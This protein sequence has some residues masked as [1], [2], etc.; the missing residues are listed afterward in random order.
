MR[1]CSHTSKATMADISTDCASP[2]VLEP[3]VAASRDISTASRHSDVWAA[4]ENQQGQLDGLLHRVAALLSGMH[5]EVLR[6]VRTAFSSSGRQA[7]PQAAHAV[8]A[9]LNSRLAELSNEMWVEEELGKLHHSLSGGLQKSNEQLRKQLRE[10]LAASQNSYAAE[11]RDHLVS[12]LK[13]L[14]E[15]LSCAEKKSASILD[16]EADIAWYQAIEETRLDKME[17]HLKQE[18]GVLLAA[19]RSIAEVRHDMDRHSSQLQAAVQH[20]DEDMKR[21]SAD[22]D[23]RLAHAQSSTLQVASELRNT[24]ESRMAENL[25]LATR[26]WHEEKLRVVTELRQELDCLASQ[27]S[28]AVQRLADELGDVKASVEA[29]KALAVSFSEGEMIDSCLTELRRQIEEMRSGSDLREW[30]EEEL[31]K[32]HGAFSADLKGQLVEVL[33]ASQDRFASHFKG[34]ESQLRLLDK[35]L[36][37]AETN[38]V[39]KSELRSDQE[40]DLAW[41]QAI[42]Q[43]EACLR[44]EFRGLVTTLLQPTVHRLDKVEGC[45]LQE[46][47]DLLRALQ[48]TATESGAQAERKQQEKQL[49]RIL[50]DVRHQGVELAKLSSEL[51]QSTSSMLAIQNKV[52]ETQGWRRSMDEQLT[53]LTRAAEQLPS[54]E[55]RI[56]QRPLLGTLQTQLELLQAKV[57]AI[58]AITEKPPALAPTSDW[59]RATEHK[60]DELESKLSGERRCADQC[61]QKQAEHISA[62]DTKLSN[63][64]T[65][66]ESNFDTWQQRLAEE[67]DRT[68]QTI[69]ADSDRVFNMVEQRMEPVAD[70]LRQQLESQLEDAFCKTSQQIHEDVEKQ[71]LQIEASR[72]LQFSDNVR[73]EVEGLLIPSNTIYQCLTQELRQELDVRCSRTQALGD[74]LRNEL[75]QLIVEV[76]RD[77]ESNT[78]Q[79]CTATHHSEKHIQQFSADFEARLTQLQSSAS[80]SVRDLRNDLE[81]RMTEN[82]VLSNGYWRDERS[83]VINEL[84]QHI[85]RLLTDPSG[86]VQQLAEKVEGIG[87]SAEVAKQI[88]DST[89]DS[90]LGEL[91][92][93]LEE[94][95]SFSGLR[96]WVEA[97]LEKMHRTLANDLEKTYG[98][99][100]E[101]QHDKI[102]ACQACFTAELQN[103]GSQLKSLDERLSC[104]EREKNMECAWR[105]A[106]DQ[107]AA[108]L[109]DELRGMATSCSQP[110]LQRLD[111]TEAGWMLQMK[112][113]DERLRSVASRVEADPEWHQTINQAIGSLRDEFQSSL[114]AA[115]HPAVLRLDKV[116]DCLLPEQAKLLASL[117]QTAATFGTQAE[118]VQED[119]RCQ[120]LKLDQLASELT[121]SMAC[122]TSMQNEESQAQ[123]WRQRVDE[124][125][126]T[127]TS[128]TQHLPS[129]EEEINQR[130]PFGILEN[131]LELLKAKVEAL[132]EIAEKPPLAPLPP[133][134]LSQTA[135]KVDELEKKLDGAVESSTQTSQKLNYRISTLEAKLSRSVATFD[136]EIKFLQTSFI[137]S[138]RCE[139]NASLPAVLDPFLHL[140]RESEHM[141][142]VLERRITLAADELRHQLESQ[143][144]AALC[145]TSQQI[146]EDVSA[147]ILK[148]EGSRSENNSDHVWKAVSGLL[149]SLNTT[150]QRLEHHVQQQLNALNSQSRNRVDDLQREVEVKIGE[151]DAKAEQLAKDLRSDTSRDMNSLAEETRCHVSK[152]SQLMESAKA[153]TEHT[154]HQLAE[155]SNSQEDTACRDQ[156]SQL[157][158]CK[159]S[160]ADVR[161]IATKAAQEATDEA[162]SC[163]IWRWESKLDSRLQRCNEAVSSCER[164]ATRMEDRLH[165]FSEELR[166]QI[167]AKVNNLGE[168]THVLPKRNN[169]ANNDS[170]SASGQMLAEPALPSQLLNC[171]SENNHT[172]CTD[173][174]RQALSQRFAH[175]GK[176]L[177][178]LRHGNIDP[179]SAEVGHDLEQKINHSLAGL[180]A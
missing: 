41:R 83:Q 75:Q 35:R 11:L 106:I 145:E 176:A 21:L 125:L 129:L 32:L 126:E 150:Y 120:G 116:E 91:C 2:I 81:T 179:R 5:A 26:Y 143:L 155:Y 80:N 30:V 20:A 133:T 37:C 4:I 85:D 140:A 33:A 172:A 117:K 102:T 17:E 79:I 148:M 13:S 160:S 110:A 173:D 22:L 47:G 159:L 162:A 169:S 177:E 178:F 99:V 164:F 119:L 8:E 122:M 65:T 93:E 70:K 151:V 18:H 149:E 52:S 96:E 114:Q 89:L 163:L 92:S 56:N 94:V 73:K 108:S 137:E 175:Q 25:V 64:I 24:L 111:E 134:G 27:P 112:S 161:R 57:E 49:E 45:L 53:T 51:A 28:S 109:R 103:L 76:R 62:V 39:L 6:D 167:A 88:A 100:Q 15:R 14:D 144:T 156:E 38:V 66:L 58:A 165:D 154:Q 12:Q 135:Q 72:P 59:L 157:Q 31:G 131:Q 136:K 68:R 147:K 138:L 3:T 86:A 50:D 166:V 158:V 115:L 48:K 36:S 171:S 78:S 130:P 124:Q 74:E 19:Q 63:K 10:E 60:I 107:S 46:H 141:V 87:V 61:L 146:D 77:I 105:Q 123:V 113:L 132:A 34:L 97:E 71:M 40:V 170:A 127:L 44:E 168:I 174:S 180:G 9:A 118:Q 67:R 82:L 1:S 152:L 90:R 128:A 69:A 139:Q 84:R 7:R 142:S 42:T 101:L 55:E 23:S 16:E 104:T 121:Q 98:Q 153:A 95:R 29:A 43:S 54:L